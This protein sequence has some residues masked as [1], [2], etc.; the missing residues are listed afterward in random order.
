VIN[1]DETV[2]WLAQSESGDGQY[3]AIFNIS[4]STA[5]LRYQWK[6]LGLAGKVYK[7]HDLWQHKDLESAGSV[8][9]TLPPHSSALYRV[10][11]VPDRPR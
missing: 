7:L 6:D 2:V 8:T 3:L 9:V 11:S 1:T 5:V 10:S 4:E